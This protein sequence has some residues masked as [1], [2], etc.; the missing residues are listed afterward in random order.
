MKRDVRITILKSEVDER[1]A[2][3]YAIPN[4]GPCLFHKAGQVFVSDGEHKPSGLCDYA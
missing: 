1:L 2:E 3:E 4:F